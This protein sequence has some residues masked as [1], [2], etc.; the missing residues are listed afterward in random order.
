MALTTV[1]S[2]AGGGLT[3]TE[4]RLDGQLD[5]VQ[6]T[7][8]RRRVGTPIRPRGRSAQAPLRVN[9]GP[10]SGVG[11]NAGMVMVVD[12]SSWFHRPMTSAGGTRGA[13]LEPVWA[14]RRGDQFD[15][16]CR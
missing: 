14:G 10:E 13:L 6:W 5:I 16:A 8:L 4:R 11:H 15:Q 2:P 9:H 1:S 7:A 12:A 3:P